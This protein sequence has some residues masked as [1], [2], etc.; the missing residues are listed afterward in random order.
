[1]PCIDSNLMAILYARTVF[2][3]SGIEGMI[4]VGQERGELI[5][6][7]AFQIYTL[8]WM[9]MNHTVCH[10]FEHRLE[11]PSISWFIDIIRK[12]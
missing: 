9:I 7:D 6:G 10:C 4:K 5:E 12:R 2:F 3:D 11:Y 8:F 1:M